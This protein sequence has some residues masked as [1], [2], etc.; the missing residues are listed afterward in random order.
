MSSTQFPTL[1]LEEFKTAIQDISQFE[2]ES[3]KNQQKH[4]IFKLI[5]T[6]NE[7]W[8]EINNIK[9]LQ[10]SSSFE[11]KENLILYQETLWE[12][13]HSLLEQIARIESINDE[14]IRRNLIKINKKDI[15]NETQQK[16]GTEGKEEEEKANGEGEDEGEGEG[17]GEGE[18]V[19]L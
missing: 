1:T 5:D 19:Y 7:L 9:Q 12:N 15:E 6:N 17:K 4:F 13:K 14:L 8:Q 16:D 10:D 18:G 11:N 3:K 2:L